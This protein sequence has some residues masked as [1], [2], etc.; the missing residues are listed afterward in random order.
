MATVLI[1]AKPNHH[2]FEDR[3]IV[4]DVPAKIGRSHKNDQPDSSNAFFDCKVLS[5]QHALILYEGG[6]FTLADTS[7]SNGTFVNNV[8]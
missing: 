6:E 7:S 3:A 5:K 2:A 1:T 4:L 8:R